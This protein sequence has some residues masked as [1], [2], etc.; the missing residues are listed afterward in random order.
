[1]W[2]HFINS[3]KKSSKKSKKSFEQYI[4]VSVVYIKYQNGSKKHLACIVSQLKR[5]ESL[6]FENFY[7]IFWYV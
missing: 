7:G 3:L 4:P 1:M 2:L 5:P 6:S